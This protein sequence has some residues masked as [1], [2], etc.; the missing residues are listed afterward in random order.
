VDFKS[1]YH[2][3]LTITSVPFWL[4]RTAWCT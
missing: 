3:P 4:L 2:V 1:T